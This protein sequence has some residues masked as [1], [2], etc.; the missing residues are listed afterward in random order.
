FDLASPTGRIAKSQPAEVTLTGRYLYGAPAARLSLEGE[1]VVR[2]ADERP[3]FAGYQF[4]LTDE[5]VSA[6]RQALTDLGETDDAGKAK[7]TVSLD[8]VPS[9]SRPLE[10]QITVRLNENG[11]RAVERKLV[12][13]VT[14]ETTLV[15]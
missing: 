4:G 6:E 14:P 2:E 7:F 12:L 5:Q 3:G 11:G 15:G 1:L 9:T 13:P 10:A 8:K